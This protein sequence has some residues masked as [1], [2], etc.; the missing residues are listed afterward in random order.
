MYQV[1]NE[2]KKIDVG[3][4]GMLIFQ[5]RVFAGHGLE[6]ER[7]RFQKVP[8]SNPPCNG[9]GTSRQLQQRANC[10]NQGQLRFNHGLIRIH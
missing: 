7:H 3:A 2:L 1:C 8:E 6:I 4:D 9:L 10:P 5:T